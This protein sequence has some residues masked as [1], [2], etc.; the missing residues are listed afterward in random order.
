[1]GFITRTAARSL[2]SGIFIYSGY[3]MLNNAERYAKQASKVLPM[4]PEEPMLAKAHGITMMAAG[5]TFALG[6]FPKLSA[7]ILA[8][9]LITNTYVGHQFWKAEKPEDQR[10]QLIQF[11]KN[12][13][14]LGGLLYVSSDRRSQKRS[15]DSD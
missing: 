12:A 2:L 9:T 8:L 15:H 6:V 14:L 10:S 4:L 13:G 11:L 3:G 7:R 5:S 1:M